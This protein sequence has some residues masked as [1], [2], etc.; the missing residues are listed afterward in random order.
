MNLLKLRKSKEVDSRGLVSNVELPGQADLNIGTRSS[1]LSQCEAS[2]GG[3]NHF[4]FM[5]CYNGPRES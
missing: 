5:N 3:L 4:D 1:C 2:A